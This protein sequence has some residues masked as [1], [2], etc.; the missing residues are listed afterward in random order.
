MSNIEVLVWITVLFFISRIF[1]PESITNKTSVGLNH[2]V[3]CNL[4]FSWVRAKISSN[5]GY[6]ARNIRAALP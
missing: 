3:S 2:V 4:N 6:S 5:H 1:L